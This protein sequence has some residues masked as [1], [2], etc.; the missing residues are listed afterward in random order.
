MGKAPLQIFIG[1]VQ[2][3]PLI[4]NTGIAG[5][6][7]NFY[8]HTLRSITTLTIEVDWFSREQE[9]FQGGCRV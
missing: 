8:F 5:A 9:S 6:V 3:F 4:L 2:S 1:K 7:L